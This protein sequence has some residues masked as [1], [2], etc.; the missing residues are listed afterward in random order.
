MTVDN[1]DILLSMIVI[2]SYRWACSGL[3]DGCT[4]HGCFDNGDNFVC[5]HGTRESQATKKSG[6]E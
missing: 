4:E 1:A 3:P 5:C 6:K 2:F